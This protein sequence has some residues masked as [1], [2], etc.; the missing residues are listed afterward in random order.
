MKFFYNLGAWGGGGGGWCVTVLFAHAFPFQVIKEL[1][2]LNTY[3]GEVTDIKYV[4]KTFSVYSLY[5]FN[6]KR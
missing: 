4:L 5:C 1:N 3:L 2:Y 6:V